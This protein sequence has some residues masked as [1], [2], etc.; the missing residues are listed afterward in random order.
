MFHINGKN[1]LSFLA[2]GSVV[3]DTV[4]PLVVSL[5]TGWKIAIVVAGIVGVVALF[6]QMHFQSKEDH[7]RQQNEQKRDE[8][9]QNILSQ[10][11]TLVPR[12]NDRALTAEMTSIQQPMTPPVTF[13]ASE[14]FKA[15]YQSQLT[16]DSEKRVRAAAILNKGTFTPEEFY[17]KFIGIGLIAY[18]HDIT[19]AYIWKSLT[20]LGRDFLTYSAHWS[21]TPDLRK[22]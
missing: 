12:D 19:W 9:Q 1:G 2:G 8:V 3:F 22:G 14:Y 20:F 13:D 16:A 11:S 17:A 6:A 15:A 4:V 18:N 10:L 5:G 7:E 21:R